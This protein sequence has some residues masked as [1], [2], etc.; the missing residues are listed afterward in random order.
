M[1]NLAVPGTDWAQ[2]V[3]R[4][5]RT[6]SVSA[7]YKLVYGDP[8]DPLAAAPE[9]ELQLNDRMHRLSEAGG[10]PVG[11]TVHAGKYRSAGG[12]TGAAGYQL[13]GCSVPPGL[14]STEGWGPY[15]PEDQPSRWKVSS[16]VPSLLWTVNA[17]QW[18]RGAV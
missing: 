9:T 15:R 1:S 11:G 3:A 5:M 6:A 16:F 12:G 4:K 13:R 8:K 17:L 18:A 10:R 7:D 2:T 14:P